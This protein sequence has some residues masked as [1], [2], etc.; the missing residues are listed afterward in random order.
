MGHREGSREGDVCLDFGSR[1]SAEASEFRRVYTR[2]FLGRGCVSA[3]GG[4]RKMKKKNRKR[5]ASAMLRRKRNKNLAQ[6]LHVPWTSLETF[7]VSWDLRPEKSHRVVSP[8]IQGCR[9]HSM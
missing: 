5:G 3:R 9:A 8:G 1:L 7:N 4:V 2:V 6:R